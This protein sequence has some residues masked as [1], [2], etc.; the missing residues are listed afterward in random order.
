[1]NKTAF[2]I[3]LSL[4]LLVSTMAET[5]LVNWVKANPYPY[6]NCD[7]S[8]VTVS[9]DSP[10]NKT[11]D[12]NNI[13]LTVNAGAYPGVWWVKY[14]VD[15]GPFKAIESEHYLGHGF[16]ES[17]WLNRLSKGSHSVKVE[18]GTMSNDSPEGVVT[19][20]SQANFTITTFLKPVLHILSFEEAVK[21]ADAG[22]KNETGVFD[23]YV[24][25]KSIE[26]GVYNGSGVSGYLMWLAPDGTL[27]EVGFPDGNTL[28]FG[29]DGF[30]YAAGFPDG[31]NSMGNKI[32][33]MAGQSGWNPP[34]GYYIWNLNYGMRE[35]Y[36]VLANNGT[37]L[38]YNPP[39]MGPTS[40]AAQTSIP[41]ELIFATALL[42]TLIIVSSGLLVYFRKRQR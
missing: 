1:M 25:Y 33:N 27:Y 35:E 16:K 3:T 15:G 26:S 24:I 11:Y 37:V 42:I 36:W 29:Q 10:E 18:A 34:D 9:I 22:S 6:T 17:V 38:L 39:N 31:G 5:R 19:A 40:P 2:A 14:S 23:N 30:L 41:N 4:A 20:T 7:S 8:F 21:A 13:L 28:W 12:T 32:G